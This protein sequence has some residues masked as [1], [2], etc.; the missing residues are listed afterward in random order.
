IEKPGLQSD[1]RFSDPAKRAA[2]AAELVPI[3]DQTFRSAPFAHWRER[4]LHARIT[5]GLV[6]TPEQVI[7]DPALVDNDAIVPI[8]GGGDVLTRTVS[9]PVQVIGVE[10]VR[11]RRAPEVG[12][13]ND[14]VL[15]ELGFTR[16]EVEA[17]RESGAV[18]AAEQKA[19]QRAA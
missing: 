15:A 9:S 10:K 3:L 8:E 5:F 16:D 6:Q 12:E 7:E 1:E 14:Q 18:P 4:L 11:A 17:L 19:K 2:N 13:H